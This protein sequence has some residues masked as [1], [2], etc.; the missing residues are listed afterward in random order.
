MNWLISYQ[1]SSGKHLQTSPNLRLSGSNLTSPEK[2]AMSQQSILITGCSS[3]I[4][5]AAAHE[6]KNRGYRV[7]ATARKETDVN[8]LRELGFESVLLDVNDSASIDNALSHILSLTGG[9]LDALF[10]NAGYLQAGAVEDL[11][12]ESTRAQ[13]ETNVFG[14]M[15][16]VR[17]VLPTMRQQGHGRIIQ[18]SSILGVITLPY[19]G[20]YNASKFALE[21]FSNT[22]RQEL[23]GTGISVSIINPGPIESE[24]RGKA[25]QHYQAT[26][27]SIPTIHRKAY[28]RLESSYFKDQQKAAPIMQKPDA[29]VKQLIH[30]LE[31]RRPKAHYYI[32]WPAQFLAILRRILPD[33][34]LDFALSKIS[35]KEGNE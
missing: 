28:E 33:G 25:Y 18:N 10:N 3:G 12:R 26:L 19:Y 9:T 30:A 11:T 35:F 17:A 23:H 27:Q 14:P 7:F 6:L 8:R 20:A 21:G 5:L 16:L 34:G 15:A 2:D 32:G 31:S 1:S 4:G 13:F 29:V 22:L 24:L